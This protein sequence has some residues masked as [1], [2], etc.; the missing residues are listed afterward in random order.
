[1]WIC[2][3]HQHTFAQRLVWDSQFVRVYIKLP[4]GK[5]YGAR[6][7][8]R[9]RVADGLRHQCSAWIGM[10][11]YVSNWRLTCHNTVGICMNGYV[12][13]WRLAY[14]NSQSAILIW[15]ASQILCGSSVPCVKGP[16]FFDNYRA[17]LWR[18]AC[19]LLPLAGCIFFGIFGLVVNSQA[20]TV[21]NLRVATELFYFLLRGSLLTTLW[22]RGF[23]C[24]A[25]T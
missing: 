22:T 20:P 1:M 3:S 13:N 4:R 8:G 7:A 25:T 23:L 6:F 18:L 12:S 19:Y 11:G 21:D 2:R 17:P 24:S 10:N 9:A 15:I 5:A 14:H 16:T